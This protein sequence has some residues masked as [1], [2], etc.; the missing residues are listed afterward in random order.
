[1]T[2]TQIGKTAAQSV[3][4]CRQ[5]AEQA[6]DPARGDGARA[7]VKNI[8][9][10]NVV[11]AHLADRHGAGRNHAR[12]VFPEKLDRRDQNQISKHA[13]RAH[14]RRDPRPNDVADSEQ[15]R[16]DLR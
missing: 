5:G 1:M 11:R 6:D 3:Q 14:D 16:R 4:D 2:A 9:A 7:D 15:C 8:R 10:A 13:T 12:C